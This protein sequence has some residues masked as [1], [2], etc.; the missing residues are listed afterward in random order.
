MR[1]FYPELKARAVEEA[2]ASST[3]RLY[4]GGRIEGAVPTREHVFSG[5][6]SMPEPPAYAGAVN[7]MGGLSFGANIGRYWGAE[8]GLDGY[9]MRL[10]NPGVGILGEYS[11]VSV[12][13][14]VRL[15][16]PLLGERLVPYVLAGVGLNRVE[17]NDKSPAGVNLKV[18]GKNIDVAGTIG[19]GVEYFIASNL[20]FGFEAE[21]LVSRD[22]ELIIGADPPLKGHLDTVFFS[23]G[24]KFFF[25]DL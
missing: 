13:P 18:K 15:R 23:F 7:Q 12:V 17:I 25:L 21:Y 24:L 5:I 14:Q 4:F 9:E 8:L 19:A 20:A 3:T 2:N 6:E 22:N 11:V 1:I 10:R 16:Y